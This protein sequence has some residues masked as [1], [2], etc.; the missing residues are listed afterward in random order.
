MMSEFEKHIKENRAL[1][2]EH[3]ADRD[4]LWANIESRLDQPQV[5]VK[6]VKLWRTTAFRVA[7][8]II[9][10]LGVFSIIN[11][12]IN[13]PDSQDSLAMQELNDIDMHYKGLVAYQVK[14]V[15]KSSQLSEDEKQVFLGFMDELDV[16]YEVLK[17]ELQNDLDTERVLEAIVINYKK[18]IELIEKLLEQ[19][20]STKQMKNDDDVYML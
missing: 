13:T 10:A 17:L 4:K 14:L 20:N 6:T 8:T 11:I 1:F 16:E 19:I 15:N 3:K 9:L 2:D 12:W 7:A 5:E 18:R